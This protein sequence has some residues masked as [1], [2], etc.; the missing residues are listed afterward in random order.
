MQY[1][2]KMPPLAHIAIGDC[3]GR[4]PAAARGRRRVDGGRKVA[5]LPPRHRPTSRQQAGDAFV[6]ILPGA[7][8]ALRL[9]EGGEGTYG[10]RPLHG[11]ELRRGKAGQPRQWKWCQHQVPCCAVLCFSSCPGTEVQSSR[12]HHTL[13]GA[14]TGWL[15]GS[16]PLG[17]SQTRPARCRCRCA[18][19][20]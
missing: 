10:Q 13:A 2:H 20:T 15:S 8:K 14:C 17:Q 4:Q 6:R 18:L 12:G 5:R 9:G 11:P 19:S 16:S 3:V 7:D 1:Q